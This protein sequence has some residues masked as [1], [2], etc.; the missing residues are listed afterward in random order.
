M[1]NEN[2]DKR[3]YEEE[4]EERLQEEYQEYLLVVGDQVGNILPYNL[5][6]QVRRLNH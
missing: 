4:T 3:I 5:W 6:K 1:T 2:E